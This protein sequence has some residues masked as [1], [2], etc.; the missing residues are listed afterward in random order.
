MGSS[1]FTDSRDF[2]AYRLLTSYQK[3]MGG[4]ARV[5][6]ISVPYGPL[7]MLR[8]RMTL[9]S[10]IHKV[11]LAWFGGLLIFVSS[12]FACG[13][14][15]FDSE[16]AR[17]NDP[18]PAAMPI[19]I[20][21]TAGEAV[22]RKAPAYI[23]ATGSLEADEQS[24]IAPEVSGQVAAAPVDVSAF[25]RQGD[26]IA[27]LNDRD[28][29][30]RLQQAQ[31]SQQ[32]AL[33]ALRQAEAKLGLGP[34]RLSVQQKRAWQRRRLRALL[35]SSCTPANSENFRR[36]LPQSFWFCSARQT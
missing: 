31:G 21:V 36:E 9:F 15:G 17:H 32:Q 24:D 8:I 13:R 4:G 19:P 20:T 35:R 29:K 1:L 11:H 28:A 3:A 18:P 23:Q 33:A 6:L 16:E 10:R 12:L 5:F 30:L 2:V 7:C 22:S 27:R 34:G 14:P 26:V 25:V